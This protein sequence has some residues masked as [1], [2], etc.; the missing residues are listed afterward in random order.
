MSEDIRNFK[1]YLTISIDHLREMDIREIMND[2]F[3]LVTDINTYKMEK[4]DILSRFYVRL[5]KEDKKLFYDTFPLFLDFLRNNPE[6]DFFSIMLNDKKFNTANLSS[7]FLRLIEK[8]ALSVF[9]IEG[10]MPKSSSVAMQ[11]SFLS[12]I[13]KVSPEGIMQDK[14]L[15]LLVDLLI[16]EKFLNLNPE[17]L[18]SFDF[19]SGISKSLAMLATLYKKNYPIELILEHIGEKYGAQFLLF[20]LMMLPQNGLSDADMSNIIDMMDNPVFKNM[21]LQAKQTMEN[22][23]PPEMRGSSA[24]NIDPHQEK[25]KNR[26]RHPLSFL[27][28]KVRNFLL[29]FLG[30]FKRF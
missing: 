20:I 8:G 24:F 17:N 2:V 3:S 19:I 22:L 28:D 6:I 1:K 7:L 4:L 9:D 14:I 11:V 16:P 10:M 26:K 27:L 12:K 29:N 30:R 15:D 25:S 5:Y 21:Y 13:L 18:M 23:L